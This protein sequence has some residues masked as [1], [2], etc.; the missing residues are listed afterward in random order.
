M[1]KVIDFLTYF[2]IY[3][4]NDIKTFIKWSINKWIKVYQKTNTLRILVNRTHSEINV[5]R[6][7][8]TNTMLSSLYSWLVSHAFAALE[9]IKM[10][11]GIL[12]P[13]G[14]PPPPPPQ[15]FFLNTKY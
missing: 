13:W 1:K 8:S 5:I 7:R 15:F 3:H 4:E 10:D 14:N 12:G 9:V 2:Y 11:G 6:A